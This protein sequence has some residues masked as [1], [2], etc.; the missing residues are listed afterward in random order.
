MGHDMGMT[1]T[2]CE[3]ERPARIVHT[4][5][6]DEDWTGGETRVTTIFEETDERRPSR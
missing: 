3:I 6:F 1:G 2:F 4:E 5:V